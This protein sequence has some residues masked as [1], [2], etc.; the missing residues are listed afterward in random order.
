MAVAAAAVNLHRV[1]T[2]VRT[3]PRTGMIAAAKAA[4]R[5]AT[6]EGAAAGSPLQGKK[7]RGLKLRARD[8]IRP[9]GDGYTCR[10]QG[11]SPAGWVWATTG[12]RPHKIRRRKRGPMRTMVVQHPGTTGRGAWYRVIARCET[13]IPELFRDAMSDAVNGA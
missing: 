9:A 5:I 11:V 2:R 10:I 12:T 4:K 1:A 6:E 13:V 8:D 3:I 7:K